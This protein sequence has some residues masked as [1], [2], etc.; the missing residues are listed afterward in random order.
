MRSMAKFIAIAIAAPLAALSPAALAQT[1]NAG[2]DLLANEKPDDGTD[3]VNPNIT[4]PEWS[5]GY[6]ST[7]AGTEL[8]LFETD[9]HIDGHSFGY[10]DTFDGFDESTP[11]FSCCDGGL[12]YPSVFV[13]TGAPVELP[14]G[15]VGTGELVLHPERTVGGDP[16]AV[17]RKAVVRFTASTAG[18]YAVTALFEDIDDCCGTNNNEGPGVDVH[19]VING[20]SVFDEAIS[21]ESGEI[22]PENLPSSTAFSD[23]SILLSVGDTVDFVVGTNGH[24]FGDVTRFNATLDLIPEPTSLGL[25]GLAMV[26]LCRRRR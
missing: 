3:S 21:R 20:I 10:G 23:S 19:I 9:D 8:T 25:L 11:D 26:M 22:D 14:D 17:E 15:T 13:N 2:A 24:M 4:V 6:R 18:E 12:Q 7:A 16:P 5:Y 1:F